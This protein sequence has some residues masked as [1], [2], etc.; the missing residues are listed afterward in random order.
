MRGCSSSPALKVLTIRVRKEKGQ[1]AV[2]V[3][4]LWT[5]TLVL[6]AMRDSAFQLRVTLRNH[7]N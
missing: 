6:A 3:P 1:E 7:R 2:C 5:L 4:R